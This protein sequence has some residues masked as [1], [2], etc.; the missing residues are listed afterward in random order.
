MCFFHYAMNWAL[1]PLL[2]GGGTWGS[3]R[4]GWTVKGLA[5]E[6]RLFHISFPPPH[7]PFIPFFLSPSS[8]YSS[9]YSAFPSFFFSPNSCPSS[10]LFPFFPCCFLLCIW[11]PRIHEAVAISL[12]PVI[13]WPSLAVIHLSR[14]YKRKSPSLAARWS[15][16]TWAAV[17]R[18][19]NLSWGSAWPIL[20]SPST[21]WRST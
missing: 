15:W 12:P 6:T 20:S 9:S 14:R 8:S 1:S 2:H 18:A 16:A 21:S 4:Q 5:L 7:L 3:V 19:I 17:H 10:P 11:T 13:P